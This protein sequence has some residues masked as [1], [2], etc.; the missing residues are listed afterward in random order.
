MRIH[1]YNRSGGNMRMEGL[2]KHPLPKFLSIVKSNRNQSL[3]E[4]LAVHL[5]KR[6]EGLLLRLKLDED[7]KL[8]LEKI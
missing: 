4:V 7:A 1:K 5:D 2:R 8:P 6:V 3:P